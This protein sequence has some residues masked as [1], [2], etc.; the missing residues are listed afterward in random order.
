MS[1][2]ELSLG[3]L[4]VELGL[5]SARQLE[6]A[7]IGQERL[8]EQGKDLALGPLM[9]ERGMLD[10]G[11][12]ARLLEEGRRRSQKG[13]TLRRYE[14]KE[15]I[16]E[17]SV[18]EVYRAI[19]RD[20]DRVVAVKFLREAAA[21]RPIL[22]LRFLREAQAVARLKHPNLISVHDA[23][24]EGG[25][26][27]IVMEYVTGRPLDRIL[28]DSRPDPRTAASMIAKVARGAH[29]VHEAGIVHR[30]LKPANIH[31]TDAGEPKILDFG[32][33]HLTE[34]ESLITKPGVILGTPRY[35]APEQVRSEGAKLTGAT[36]VY[37]LGAILYELISGRPAHPGQTTFDVISSVMNDDPAPLRSVCPQVE[38]PLEVV[39]QKALAKPLCDRYPTA[40]ALAEDLERY[41]R[42]EAVSARPPSN[43]AAGPI[44][45]AAAALAAFAAA[46][47]VLRPPSAARTPKVE[48]S[49]RL[50]AGNR[51]LAEMIAKRREPRYARRDLEALAARATAEFDASPGAEGHVGAGRAAAMTGDFEAALDRFRRALQ[52]SPGCGPALHERVRI[53]GLRYE[54]RR[55]NGDGTVREEDAEARHLRGELERDIAA[56]RASGGEEPSFAEAMLAFSGGE[57][58]KAVDHLT[59]HIASSA[60]D[61]DAH[62][63]RG[64]AYTHLGRF[65]EAERDYTEALRFDT[66]HVPSLAGR[67]EARC[68]MGRAG[69]GVE[70]F[71]EGLRIE[72]SNQDLLLD[73][74]MAWSDAGRP[75]LAESDC[76]RV[77]DRHPAHARARWVRGCAR[78][79]AGKFAAAVTDFTEALRLTP[80]HAA[81]W[82]NR[83]VARRRQGDTDGAMADYVEALKIEPTYTEARINL[84]SILRD[85]KEWDRA[86][87]EFTSAIECDASSSKAYYARAIC[88]R[89]V[90]DA[91]GAFDD[92]CRAIE[93]DPRNAEAWK[94]RGQLK[95]EGDDLAGALADLLAALKALPGDPGILTNL[96]NVRFAMK[97]VRGAI[98]DYEAAM[99]KWPE[100]ANL[101]LCRGNARR[102]LNEVDGALEDFTESIRLDPTQPEAYVNRAALLRARGEPA[103]AVADL[104]KA[105]EIAP[106]GWRYREMAARQLEQAKKER[107]ERR[108]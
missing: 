6:E 67:G 69:E 106:E 50:D 44:A 92:A 104:E 102:Q 73:R 86:I 72:P 96:G 42:G 64:H 78:M 28:R 43:R 51:T 66:A 61:G 84:G 75:E 1:R 41:L 15:K 7:L 9:V 80:R 93:N 74:A 17:G 101:R 12:L 71:T 79:A 24:E 90:G 56:I 37:A 100:D 45:I 30:D 31:V 29:H 5:I 48:A 26:A 108:P 35:M 13:E 53:L 60:G 88:R 32:L 103:R 40:L 77:L 27:F 8:H 22:R 46:W 82:Y 2:D 99:V 34:A 25:R 14:L 55:H 49:S 54:N 63:W 19:D 10:A 89:A 98:A 107:D 94:L 4:A 33:A 18:A 52:A 11:R 97:D 70:D 87:A 65:A 16:G 59:R 21:L 23:G 68:R 105:L 3:Q 91:K 20:L 39:V 38:A 57:Y 47:I 85:R 83:G 95:K 58:Q 81:A 36:D 76:A 62:Y